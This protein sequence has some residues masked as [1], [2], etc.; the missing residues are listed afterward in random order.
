MNGGGRKCKNRPHGLRNFRSVLQVHVKFEA[1][2]P[3]VW[4][5]IICHRLMRSHFNSLILALRRFGDFFHTVT[6]VCFVELVSNVVY[7][8]VFGP[9]IGHKDSS[10]HF[11]LTYAIVES[12][13][14]LCCSWRGW[15]KQ[16]CNPKT[17]YAGCV[18]W[19]SHFWLKHVD[20]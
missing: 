10:A 19:L 15:I 20:V 6:D 16:I 17:G 18:P 9:P 13:Y 2:L 1:D 8:T 11:W 5:N 14:C 12:S 4:R 3:C 7:S